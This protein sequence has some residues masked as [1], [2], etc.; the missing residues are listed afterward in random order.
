MAV[1]MKIM[2]FWDV[3]LLNLNME[4]AGFWKHWCLSAKLHCITSQIIIFN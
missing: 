2:V 1:N 3:I 4:A